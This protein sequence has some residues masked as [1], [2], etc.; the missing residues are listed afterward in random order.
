[1]MKFSISDFQA[2]PDSRIKLTKSPTSVEPLY[3]SKKQY[4]KLLKKNVDALSE[5]QHKLYADN[6]YAVLLIFQGMDAAGKDGAI[7]HVMS[8]INPQGFQVFSFKQPS[9]NELEHD[10]LWR[11]VRCLPERGRIGIFNRSYYE[12][13]LIV[14]VHPDF[15]MNQ[16]LPEQL[17]PKQAFWRDRYRS[18]VEHEAHLQRSGTRIIK[19]FLH[20][21]KDEQARRFMQRIDDPDKNWKLTTADIEQRE[22]WD[23]YTRA[24]EDCINATT[25]KD[26]PWYIVP[27]DDKQNARLIIS[28]IFLKT[29]T[30]LPLA[31]PQAT[32]AHRLELQS[33]RKHLDNS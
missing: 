24:Y 14:K 20:Q 11:T 23:D 30:D 19:F 7:R 10:F 31:Y 26:A 3:S 33:I 17:P 2:L 8:G 16:R 13:V 9:N 21:S 25:T 6:R 15:L 12:E 28:E 18:I 4:Q 1:M 29:L 22:Y 5:L 27:A 32:D